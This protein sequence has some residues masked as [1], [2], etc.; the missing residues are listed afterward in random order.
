M[1]RIVRF[2][3]IPMQFLRLCH[4]FFHILF[5]RHCGINLLKFST[6]SIGNDFRQRRFAGTGRSIENDGAESCPP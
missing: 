2:L 1:N 4:H 6:G 5:A 3:Y